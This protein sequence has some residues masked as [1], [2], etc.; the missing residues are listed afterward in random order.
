MFPE[1]LHAGWLLSAAGAVLT[2]VGAGWGAYRLR[3]ARSL[4]P[5][6]VVRV[7]EDGRIEVAG[8]DPHRP[9]EGL[10]EPADPC[11][12][13]GDELSVRPSPRTPGR[14]TAAPRP[15]EALWAGFL[16]Y[17]VLLLALGAHALA[18]Q[19]PDSPAAHPLRM[20]GAVFSALPFLAAGKLA[21]V[22]TRIRRGTRVQGRVTAF[23]RHPH[24]QFNDAPA[25]QA[26]VEYEYAGAVRRAWS[27]ASY[28]SSLG[29]G[30]PVAAWVDDRSPV[31]VLTLGTG[32]FVFLAIATVA[33]PLGFAFLLGPLWLG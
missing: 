19:A 9:A 30:R 4:V 14:Y 13:P 10:L 32:L 20:V 2:A 33:G 6:A 26:Q 7:T 28:A 22:L 5:V 25:S 23:R 8:T 1:Y 16:A 12:R 15:A 24:V 27:P 29:T 3:T 31:S 17:G 11:L 21:G 18:T